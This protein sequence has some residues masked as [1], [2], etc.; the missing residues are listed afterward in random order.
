MSSTLRRLG[1]ASLASCL[2]L[3]GCRSLVY[4]AYEKVGVQKRHL[5]RRN[6]EKVQKE[7]TEA[8]E[9]FKDVLTRIKDLTGF[10]GGELES[11]YRKL[12]GDYKD[13]SRRAESIRE[14][15]ETV[16][17]IG[18][19]LFREWQSEAA[20]IS[21][22]ALRAQSE[23]ALQ[24]SQQRFSA[25]QSA[26]Q[27]AESRL[28]PVLTKVHDYVLYLKHNLNAQAVGALQ[29]EV[30]GIEREV[31]RLVEDMNRCIQQAQTFLND[32]K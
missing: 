21:S 23:T 27:Q 18:V 1:L 8:A 14:R 26:M 30:G 16:N 15:I 4:A 3:A 12:D 5:L 28:D 13:C 19:D 6:V 32:F 20:Q 24:N 29:G 9:Q 31:A 2:L 7:Q 11:V 25:L 22:A 17:H 10:D